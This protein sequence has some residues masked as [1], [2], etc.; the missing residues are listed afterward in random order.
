[1]KTLMWLTAGIGL[2][3][4]AYLI[5]NTPG[6]QYATG[7]EDIEDAARSAANWGSKRRVTG[8]ASDLAG[9]VKERVGHLTGNEEL[10]AQGLGDQVAGRVEETA[11]K[12]AQT[13]GQ[14]LHDLNR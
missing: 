4:L 10:A 13:A 11:G 6:P 5:V 9:R 12:F 8:T 2:G 3:L 14:T 1:M 7:S